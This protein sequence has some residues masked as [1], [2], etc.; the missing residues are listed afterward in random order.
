[1]STSCQFWLTNNAGTDRIRLP[2]LPEKI[3][4]THNAGNESLSVSG[5]GEITIIQDSNAILFEF[6]SHFPGT[7]H[8]GC[9]YAD[10][11]KPNEYKDKIVEWKNGA[12]PVKFIVTGSDIDLYCSIESFVFYEQGGD[13]DTLYYTIKLKE[14]RTATIRRIDTTPVVPPTTPTPDPPIKQPSKY[15]TGQVKTSGGRLNLRA[16]KST[17]SKSLALI[18]NKT[19]LDVVEKSGSWYKCIYKGT[20]G[21]CYASYIKIIS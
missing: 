3:N 8:Q 4:I 5:V 6:S 1:M 10:I 7:Y 16:S 14:Y 19:K 20:T 21:Y 18:P 13:P 15:Q 12:Q 11:K 2:V 17:S 9:N